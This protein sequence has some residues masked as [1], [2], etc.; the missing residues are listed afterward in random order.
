MG[1]TDVFFV[2]FSHINPF[3]ISALEVYVPSCIHMAGPYSPVLATGHISSP[4]ILPL[5]SLET[6]LE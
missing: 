3:N 6:E 5:N 4:W 2:S 1:L